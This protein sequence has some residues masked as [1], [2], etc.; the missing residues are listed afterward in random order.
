MYYF[1]PNFQDGHTYFVKPR[2]LMKT[3]ACRQAL[4]WTRTVC[5]IHTV[6]SQMHT[7]AT[8]AC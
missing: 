8:Y 7:N 6:K 2:K 3:N 5:N 4:N 1:P